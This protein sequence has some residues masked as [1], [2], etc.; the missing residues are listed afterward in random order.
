MSLCIKR[1]KE[2]YIKAEVIGFNKGKVILMPF[3]NL[4][5]IGPGAKV[6]CD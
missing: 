5:G 2:G 6:V 4:A 3:G 1:K